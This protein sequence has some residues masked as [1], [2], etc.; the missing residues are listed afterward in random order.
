MHHRL[1]TI[2]SRC[3]QD[4]AELLQPHTIRQLC[5]Q[6]GYQYRCRVL[7]PVTT[8]HLLILQILHGNTALGHVPLLAR[9]RFS[10]SALCQARARLPLQLFEGLLRRGLSTLTP[11]IDSQGR[12]LG[13]RTFL[14]DGSSFSMPDTAALRDEFGQPGGQAE[15]C[16]FPTAHLLVQFDAYHGYIHRLIPS[17]LRTHDMA[18][19][20]FM[21]KDL[22]PGDIVGG[23]R[24]FCSYAQLALLQQ[25][26]LCG[27]FRAHQRQIISFKVGRPH[28]GPGKAKKGQAGMPRSRWLKRLGKHDQLVE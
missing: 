4:L 27:L 16:G 20:A 10:A 3:T 25:R 11:Q 5:E 1:L 22:R 13:H 6:L 7:D 24:A 9:I 12:W 2:L 28:L 17:P 26:S 8:I 21:H 14:I 19:A 15:G 23:D 18:H